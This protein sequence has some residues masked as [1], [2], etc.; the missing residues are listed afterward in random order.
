MFGPNVL[1]LHLA[2]ACL[3]IDKLCALA[4]IELAPD[5]GEGLDAAAVQRD[6]GAM[7]RCMQTMRGGGKDGDHDGRVEECGEGGVVEDVGPWGGAMKWQA[8]LHEVRARSR[9]QS[10]PVI[11]VS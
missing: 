1:C 3:Q 6:V 11:I 5:G 7:L 8:P 9:C 10:Q 2:H 4:H